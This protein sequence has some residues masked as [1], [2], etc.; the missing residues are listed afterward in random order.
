[1]RL[2]QNIPSW[3]LKAGAL[4]LLV[5]LWSFQLWGAPSIP[6]H[7][8]EST[9]LFMSS[10]L[11]TLFSAPF[12]MVWDPTKENDLHQRYRELD[13]PLTKYI[14]GI[15]R[16]FARLP[17]LPVDWD[18]S[19][20]W[21]ANRQAGALPTT[22]L[23]STGRIA[24]T[25]LLPLSML[26][27]YFCT[28]KIAGAF[29]GFLAAF[30]LGSNALILLHNRRSMAEGA[31]TLGVCLALW[32][33]L[34]GH[35]HP[36]LAGLGAALAFNAKQST[37]ALFPLGLL[38][39]CWLPQSIQHK[40]RDMLRNLTIYLGTFLLVTLALNPLWWQNPQDAMRVSWQARREL[41]QRQVK[42][43]PNQPAES[44]QP[45]QFLGTI[46]Y[47]AAV[48]SANLTIAPLAFY[49]IGNYRQQTAASEQ[50]YL[51]NPL[52]TFQRGLVGGSLFL[53]LAVIGLIAALL[54]IK[55]STPD[56]RRKLALLLLSMFMQTAA[57][58]VFV[59]LPWQRYVI[60]VLPF[61]CIWIAYALGYPFKNRSV[62]ND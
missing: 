45:I 52:H 35:R 44:Q 17:A 38:A 33:F 32:G 46:A 48:L 19:K 59:P 43:I 55:K 18:W 9:Q 24:I 30:L 34:E 11:E 6:F 13:A 39:V 42:D 28:Q 10:D 31:L 41:L 50:T 5:G 4:A 16:Q 8:D 12:S 51:A 40:G 57:L 36:W 27:L 62:S 22:A 20:D 56:D 7:P 53:A 60:P 23:L 61:L 54:Q 29:S 3:L 15:G 47:R 26:C 49:E 58:L 25:L 1:M 14:L 2:I 21:E 37:L